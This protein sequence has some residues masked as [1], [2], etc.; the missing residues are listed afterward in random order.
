MVG[1]FRRGEEEID[2]KGRKG[3]YFYKRGG[4]K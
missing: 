3:W 1:T 2:A 4:R